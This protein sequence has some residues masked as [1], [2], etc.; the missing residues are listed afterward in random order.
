MDE[1]KHDSQTDS[2]PEHT[3]SRGDRHGNP[4]KLKNANKQALARSKSAKQQSNEMNTHTHRQRHT[5]TVTVTV[6]VNVAPPPPPPPPPP[7]RPQAK[8]P[9]P[10]HTPTTDINDISIYTSMQVIQSIQSCYV[11][12]VLARWT[13]H[14][15]SILISNDWIDRGEVV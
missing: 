11:P 4:G 12:V 14:L 8:S 7:R 3:L 5:H 1:R 2:H 10:T 9:S 6:T 15:H 13:V